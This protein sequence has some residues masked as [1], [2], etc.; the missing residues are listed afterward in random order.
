MRKRN[1]KKTNRRANVLLMSIATLLLLWSCQTQ[2]TSS[3]EGLWLVE[4][5]Q[6]GEDSM[7]PIARWVKFSQDHTQTSGNGWLQHS[8]GTWS[9]EGDQLEVV[10]TNGIK[11]TDGAL[12]LTLN[13]DTMQWKR[14]EGDQNV[15]ISLK[16]VDKIPQSEGNK[17]IGLWK[18]TQASDNGNDITAIVNPDHKAM[19]HLRW[20]NMYVQHN[21]PQGKVYGIYRIHAHKPE[22]QLVNYGNPSQFSFWNFTLE[23]QKLKLISTDQKSE[24]IFERIHQF[25]Q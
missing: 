12:T 4:K 25:I 8:S 18:L 5:V 23:G 16:K 1:K 6:V 15:T 11:D 21:M 20:D 2:K 22:I 7:T 10:D 19:M 9:L 24:M 17:L 14:V 13:G 3:I